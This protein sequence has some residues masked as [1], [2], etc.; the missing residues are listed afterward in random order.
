MGTTTRPEL[1]KSNEFWIERHRYYELK[2]FCR[3]YPIWEKAY[4]GLDGLSKGHLDLVHTSKTGTVSDPTAKCAE[5]RLFYSE[6]MDMIKRAAQE[7]DAKL[8]DYI[9]TGVTEGISY[10]WLRAKLGVP[11]C[12]NAY[13]ELYRRF[14]WILNKE[15]R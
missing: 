13:Y 5:A 1:S 12:K 8:G 9:L 10:D 2:H 15:R 14:F 4:E 6:R 3:Q 7:A 11:C